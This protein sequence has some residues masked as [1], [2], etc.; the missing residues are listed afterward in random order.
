HGIGDELGGDT[1]RD[2]IVRMG[3][4]S[5]LEQ[6]FVAAAFCMLGMM[7]A[8]F[9]VSLTLRLHQEE[10]GQR[11][12]TVLSGSV[13]RSRWLTSHLVIALI[14]SSVAIV[15]PRGGAGLLHGIP[16]PPPR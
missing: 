10:A 8:A 1:A 3:G 14:G 7:A 4:T 9:A 16:P 2:I 15:V 5:A 6:A 12:E 11:A 13:S